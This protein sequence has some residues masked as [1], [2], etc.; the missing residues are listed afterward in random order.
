MPRGVAAVAET[1]EEAESQVL[2]DA[3]N[4]RVLRSREID[5]TGLPPL[6]TGPIPQHWVVVV[7]HPNP[8]EEAKLPQHED[9]E[10]HCERELR[11]LYLKLAVDPDLLV[12]GEIEKFACPACGDPIRLEMPPAGER[13]ARLGAAC[14]SCRAPLKRSSESDPWAVV[15]QAPRSARPCVFCH[16]KADSYEHV[17]PE[18]ISRRLG[19]RDFLSADS[20]F[21]GAGAER[22]TRPISFASYRSR[23]FCA[24]CNTHFKHLE[25]AVIPLLAPMARGFTLSLDP[26]SQALLA[27]W[28]H[29]TA[30]ALVAATPE[31]AAAVP[32]SHRRAVRD[33]ESAGNDTWVAFF[34]WQGGHIL[35]TA[36]M[37]LLDRASSYAARDGYLAF[38]T[39]AGIGFAVIGLAEPLWANETM[40]SELPPLARFWPP[41]TQLQH[42]PPRPVDNSILPR[43]L[44]FAPVR[45]SS[46]SH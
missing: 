20:A 31:G 26:D 10:T 33:H 42:W 30:I 15:A 14:S 16:A 6:P 3:P 1:R 40:D 27:L 38:L 5:L 46:S 37:Q 25:D 35:G 24:G 29:K 17:I 11:L 2:A 43:L 18:W 7:E 32:E 12:T 34:A 23:I 9:P 21:V 44:G 36:N 41:R 39:F 13:R 28:A 8:D 22:P 4:M 19:V 45:A